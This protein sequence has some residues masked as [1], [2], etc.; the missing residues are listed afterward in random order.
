MEKRELEL[1]SELMELLQDK[2]EYSEGD[3]AE[4]LGK[5]KPEVA[6]LEIEKG[7]MSELEEEEEE[8]G[9]DLDA[10]MEEGESMEH[11]MKVMGEDPESE[12]KKRIMKMRA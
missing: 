11:K 2:M 5:K 6:V 9:M 10:D 3:F 7:P 1:I 4:R 8:L 12:L